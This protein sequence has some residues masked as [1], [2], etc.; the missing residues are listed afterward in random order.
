MESEVELWGRILSHNKLI[1]P[2]QWD[3]LVSEWQDRGRREPLADLVQIAGYVSAK[4]REHI[5]KMV[6]QLLAKQGSQPGAPGSPAAAAKPAQ[7]VQPAAH[8]A[9]DEPAVPATVDLASE[10]SGNKIKYHL[11]PGRQAPSDI[12]QVDLA[13]GPPE[14]KPLEIK[15]HFKTTREYNPTEDEVVELAPEDD[16]PRKK[17]IVGDYMPPPPQQPRRTDLPDSHEGDP[18]APLGFAD[19][20]ITEKLAEFKGASELD[21]VE[22]NEKAVSKHK[23]SDEDRIPLAED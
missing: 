19:E 17:I 5:A 1:K 6:A 23:V 11:D 13:D 12:L 9:P 4:Q 20:S 16:G 7:A 8:H 15:M 18:D 3:F 10:L 22:T 14:G 21:W 2:A